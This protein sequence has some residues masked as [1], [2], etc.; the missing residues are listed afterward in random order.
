MPYL[1]Q[2]PN[3][4]KDR[5]EEPSPSET[6]SPGERALRQATQHFCAEPSE[7]TL[8]VLFDLLGTMQTQTCALWVNSYDKAFTL[9]GTE[10]VSTQGPSGPCGLMETAVFSSPVYNRQG[11]AIRFNQYRTHHRVTKHNAPLC[12]AAEAKEEDKDYVA[13]WK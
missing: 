1:C 6:L 9:R 7:A 4:G 12:P 11:Q 2:D 10:W 3:L 8:R 13:V 5:G